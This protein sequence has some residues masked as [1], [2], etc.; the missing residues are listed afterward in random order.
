MSTQRTETNHCER[1][2]AVC[3][4]QNPDPKRRRPDLC[5]DCADKALR[6]RLA[7]VRKKQP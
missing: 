3:E 1:C 4:V 6:V 2:G 7:E 5:G